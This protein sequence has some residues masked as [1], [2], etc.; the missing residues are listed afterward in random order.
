MTQPVIATFTLTRDEYALA[1]KRHCYSALQPG[2]DVV[3]GILAIV[4]GVYLALNSSAGWIGWCLLVAGIL[5]LVT[6]KLPQLHP[7]VIAS[8]FLL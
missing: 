8:Q 4:G 6:V 5:L 1:L 3:A 7:P 2:R